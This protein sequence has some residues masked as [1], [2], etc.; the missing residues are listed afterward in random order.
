MNP[1]ELERMISA[2]LAG[3]RMAQQV[4]DLGA[5]QI[6]TALGHERDSLEWDAAVDGAAAYLLKGTSL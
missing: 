1:G 3:N 6:A 5:W 2:W 4:S